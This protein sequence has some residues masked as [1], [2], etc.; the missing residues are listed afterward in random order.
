ML[1][2]D[3]ASSANGVTRPH[4][5]ASF[6]LGVLV[7]IFLLPMFGFWYAQKLQDKRDYARYVAPKEGDLVH[8]L[9]QITIVSSHIPY[10]EV[11]LDNGR[12]LLATFLVFPEH[13][14]HNLY[15]KDTGAFDQKKMSALTTCAHAEFEF[16]P[17][18]GSLISY[19]IYGL[20]CNGIDVLS[21]KD[22]MSYLALRKP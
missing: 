6:C 11:R 1:A 13:G 18:R 9:G 17:I 4:K 2:I 5:R 21:Y 12:D 3:Q 10:L 8:A 7:A 19:W 14:G 22:T 20:R 15:V 16:Y